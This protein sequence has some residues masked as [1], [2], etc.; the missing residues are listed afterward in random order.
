MKHTAKGCSSPQHTLGLPKTKSEPYKH[1]LRFW[2]RNKWKAR[3][4]EAG[5]SAALADL[6]LALLSRSGLAH[7]SRKSQARE[8]TKPYR[9]WACPSMSPPWHQSSQEYRPTENFSSS[10]PHGHRMLK[11]SGQHSSA[12]HQVPNRATMWGSVWEPHG[13][14]PIPW[15]DFIFPV[16]FMLFIWWWHVNKSCLG[17]L[18]KDL[19]L[20]W[21]RDSIFSMHVFSKTPHLNLLK[22]QLFGMPT[23]Q[24]LMVLI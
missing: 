19:A 16:S 1:V 13:T 24:R 14:P 2:N 20:G 22:L 21:E 11:Q 15:D 9:C 7:S 10:T 3:L 18:E 12:S 6:L 5:H 4:Q 8:I 23:A 17:N